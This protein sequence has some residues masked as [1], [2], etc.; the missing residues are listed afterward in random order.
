MINE[1]VEVFEPW[2]EV[3][4]SELSGRTQMGQ[5]AK[6]GLTHGWV[7]KV[8]KT[9]SRTVKAH[10]GKE[11]I[12]DNFWVGGAKPNFEKPDRVFLVN[13]MYMKKN[14]EHCDFLELKKFILEN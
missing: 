7:V 2:H 13:K 10:S 4:L 1:T 9:K 11:T 12:E 6:L 3:S 8:A 14:M 5:A